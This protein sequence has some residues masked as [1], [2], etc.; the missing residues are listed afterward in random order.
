MSNV[1][2]GP[3]GLDAS[4]DWGRDTS[5]SLL[6]RILRKEKTP[7]ALKATASDESTDFAFSK[8]FQAPK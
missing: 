3:G 4:L 5:G 1:M 7:E 8:K 6:E 2:P